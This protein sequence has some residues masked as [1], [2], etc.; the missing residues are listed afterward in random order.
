MLELFLLSTRAGLLESRWELLCPLCRGS[1]ATVATLAGVESSVHCDSC[2]IDVT[3]DFERSIELTFRPSP[4]IR[5]VEIHEFCV[6]GPALTP[7]IVAQQLL[8]PGERRAR[9]A[10]PGARRVPGPRDRPRRCR[11]VHGSGGRVPRDRRVREPDRRRAAV[12]RSNEPPGPTRRRPRLTSPHSGVPRP[13]RRGGAAA[14][15]EHGGR[16][17]DG[18]LH[19]SA[20]LDPALS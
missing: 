15:R 9:D 11:A 6:G 16:E 20:G 2:H 4:A 12:P 8:A 14:R 17:P 18:R 19:R 5:E 10:C 3:A 1:A 13:V 7:H